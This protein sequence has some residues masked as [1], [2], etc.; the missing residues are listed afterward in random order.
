MNKQRFISA[1]FF[2]LVL[3]FIVFLYAGEGDRK[4]QEGINQNV[5]QISERITTD[6]VQDSSFSRNGMIGFPETVETIMNRERITV[7]DTTPPVYK[8]KN[9]IRRDRS[10]LPQNPESPQT[11]RYPQAF[12]DNEPL[13]DAPQTVSTNFTSATLSGTNP[14]GAFP[15]DNMGAV[16]PSQFITAVNGRIVSFNKSTGAADGIINAS[17]DVFFNSVRNGSGTSDPR[18]RYD[19]LSQ[20]WY[21]IIINVSTPN[22]ILLS[23]SSTS[24]ITNSTTWTFY[25][26][27][28]EA[29]TP[30]ISNTCL[31][32]YPTLGID[33]NALYIGT[34]NFCGSPTQSFNSTDGYVVN[35][36]SL[37]TGTM[38]LKVFR[39][40]LP[41]SSSAGPYT[42]QGIDNFDASASE[43][44]FIGV[45]NVAF[46]KLTI[47]RV[48]NP[49]GTPTISSNIDLTVPT[50][51][52][53]VTVPHSGNTGGTN[54][55]LDALD[56]RLFAAY[57]RNGRLWTAHNINVN[58]SGVATGSRSRDAIRWYEINNLSTTPSLVQ[59]GTV[60]DAAAS[61][62][63]YYW[64]PTISVS[65][66]GH[67]AVGFSTAGAN[68]RIDAGITGRLS[69]DALG[70]MQTPY[71]YTSSSTAYNPSGDPGGSYGR[72]WGDYSYVS[73]DPEDDMTM[74]TVQQFCNASNSYGVRVAKL[75]APPPA[76]LTSA[77]LSSLPMN[78]SSVDVTIYGTSTSGSGFFDPGSGFAKR[79]SASL[80]L[81]ITVNSI[82]YVSPTQV[83][84]NLSTVSATAGY[85]MLTI[86]NPDGQQVSSSSLFEVVLPISLSSFN[87]MVSGRSVKLNW[88]TETELNN[89]GF[90]VER[91]EV[92][93]QK[94]EFSKIGFINGH[95][96]AN[97]PTNYSFEDKNLNTGKY[98]YR[99][100]QNDHNGNYEYFELNG[101][102]E[103]GVPKKYDISQNY[104]NPFN[105]VT[106]I[107]FD[108][109]EN[110]RVDLRLY[111][112]LGR[113]VAVLVN[114]VRSAGYHTVQFDASKLSSGI[115]F[116]KMN[117]GKFSGIKKM[118]VLK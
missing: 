13:T 37:I 75:L 110:G 15:P 35:K 82:T 85:P 36:Q 107:N 46:G 79:I 21:V 88:V 24:D 100:K 65:G 81:N 33:A 74:W 99:L 10:G 28:I 17:T 38:V 64:I 101:E 61:N 104:P 31:A 39:G 76:S 51:S 59:S 115:Y 55:Y 83:Q 41:T 84:L 97:T 86:T 113:E 89:A 1:A 70:T 62:P 95:G 92:R 78:L 57:I 42:P 87:S 77:S 11:S 117:A 50:T 114:E 103:V 47:R 2:V 71:I 111:D 20:R 7:R 67:A 52:Y 73:V 48:S 94:L 118:A 69:N 29:V 56:D 54:G 32:D 106:K 72:R 12:Q 108:L 91:A 66:Q 112:M 5:T 14:T 63:R 6:R 60:Y 109:P 23:V 4:N 25:Y 30:T 27:S 44:Y 93:S 8:P 98:K 19:R 18:I 53:P 105:P 3:A 16:G 9:K 40:L 26:I 45:D 116:Y 80:N 58:A 96:T 34:N 68:N 90:D 49:G 22:R 43:G 102:V